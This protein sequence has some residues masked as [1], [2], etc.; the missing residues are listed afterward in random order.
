L[1][2][3]IFY[4]E[5]GETIMTK[6]TIEHVAKL[7]EEHGSNIWFQR[8]ANDL[9]P[10]G[11]TSEHSP[12]GKFTKETDIMHVWFDSGSSHQGVCAERDYLTYPADLY[13]EGDR[14][15]VV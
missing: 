14:K 3:S 11:F 12:N 2:I 13:L 1:P 6:E 15:S 9:L 4:G 8:E 5:D 10:E 7:F